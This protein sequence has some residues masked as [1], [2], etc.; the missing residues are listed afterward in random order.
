MRS[1][2]RSLKDQW[3]FQVKSG[4]ERQDELIETFGR[5]HHGKELSDMGFDLL[6]VEE[7]GA[8][9]GSGYHNPQQLHKAFE[10]LVSK[11]PEHAK[12]FDLTTEYKQPKT[13]EGRH[14]YAFK[15]SAN[16]AKDESKPDVLIVSNHH[17]RELITPEL[18]LNFAHRLLDGNEKARKLESGE[19]GEGDMD[20]EDVAEAQDAKDILDKNQVYVMWTMNPDGLNT[21]WSSDSWKRTNGRNVDLNR[22]YPVGWSLSCGGSTNQGG[23]TFRGPHPFSEPETKTMK[24]FQENRNFA[25]VMDFHSYAQQVRTNY[26]NC[27]RLPGGID[28]DFERGHIQ[29]CWQWQRCGGAPRLLAKVFHSTTVQGAGHA[30]AGTLLRFTSGTC[31]LPCVRGHGLTSAPA[32]ALHQLHDGLKPMLDE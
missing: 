9:T 11:H 23:E 25:K 7:R 10:E 8:F 19:L 21:V 27:A 16:A 14:M 12:L 22:N 29:P 17:A 2:T 20:S 1:A 32:E 28:K 6:E 31:A 13:I 30:C 18:A 3:H 26:G 24:A 4:A 5:H 15:L